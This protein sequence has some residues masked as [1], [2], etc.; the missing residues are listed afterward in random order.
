MVT[1]RTSEGEHGIIYMKSVNKIR[2]IL[3]QSAKNE[4]FILWMCIE[5]DPY[6]II[7]VRKYKSILLCARMGCGTSTQSRTAPLYMRRFASTIEQPLR[8]PTERRTEPSEISNI[9]GGMRQ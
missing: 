7:K 4:N 6:L 8:D 9:S 1:R 5:S 2:F 3:P